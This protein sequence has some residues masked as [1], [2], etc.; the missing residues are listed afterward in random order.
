MNAS[1]SRMIALI[2]DRF[3][4]PPPRCVR[5][6]TSTGAG[7]VHGNPLDWS[8]RSERVARARKEQGHGPREPRARVRLAEPAPLLRGRRAPARARDRPPDRL[9]ARDLLR[10]RPRQRAC[11]ARA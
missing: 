8:M 10:L 2:L 5:A 7:C 4:A 3:M 6:E 9:L 11:L 1:A